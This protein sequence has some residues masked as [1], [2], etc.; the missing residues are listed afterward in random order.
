MCGHELYPELPEGWSQ[1]PS[2][3]DPDSGQ[4]YDAD[5]QIMGEMLMNMLRKDHPEWEKT[6]WRLTHCDEGYDFIS[7]QVLDERRRVTPIAC[8]MEGKLNQLR[9]REFEPDEGARRT[10][11]CRFIESELEWLSENAGDESETMHLEEEYRNACAKLVEFFKRCPADPKGFYPLLGACA[12]HIFDSGQWIIE[13]WTDPWVYAPL[14]VAALDS[15]GYTEASA[16][17]QT[18]K[19]F[20]A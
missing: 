17:T 7:Y 2:I 11:I 15:L 1:G 9:N 19:L 20:A 5:A 4:A 8:W 16:H 3:N 18:R 12:G 10:V 6:C 14:F 13:E